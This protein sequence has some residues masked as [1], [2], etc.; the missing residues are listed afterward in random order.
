MAEECRA[1]KHSGK[2][3]TEVG[4]EGH[5]RH[6]IRREIKKVEA[7]GVHEIIEKIGERGAEPAGEVVNE[8]R[9]PIQAGLS[10]IG[11]VMCMAGCP[12]VFTPHRGLK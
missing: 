2:A 7:V 5:A 10:K 8:E 12:V 6:G 3:L 11:G 4:K 1:G 9:I